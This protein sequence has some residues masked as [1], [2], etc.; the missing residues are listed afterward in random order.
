MSAL[1]AGPGGLPAAASFSRPRTGRGRV[2]AAGLRRLPRRPR[3]RD[4]HDRGGV[5][6]GAAGHRSRDR[7]PA[8]DD[9]R[10]RLRPLPGRHRRRHRG[11]AAGA[12]AATGSGG[13]RPFIYSP[14]DIDAVMGQARSS[15]ASPLRAATYDTLIG[16]LAAT[17]LRIGEAIKLDRERPRL[18][19]RGAADPRVQVRQVP[20][21]PAAPSSMAGARRLRPAAR[22]ASA[23]PE[24]A[25]LL[26]VADPQPPVLRRGLPDV[27]AALDNAGVGADAPRRPRLHDLRHTFA[28]RTLL[29]WYRSGEDVQAKIPS[30]STYLGHREPASTYWYLSAAQN[31]SPW[32]PP[33][34]T[35]LVGGTGHDADRPDA[36]GVLHRPARQPAPSQP[37]HDRRLPRHPAPA[38]RSSCTDRPPSSP[39]RSTGTTSTPLRSRRS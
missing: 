28:V 27:P 15:I 38:A 24:G 3:L 26:R 39:P 23:A 29:G 33:A 12:D 1:G 18:V 31:C 34:R 13:A 21:G 2:A 14:A 7:R 17:G 16:L 20:P 19:R 25:E 10:P 5:G 6:V 4:G 11:A 35:P 30:L 8:A 32:P 22:R 9:G 37:A 36:A